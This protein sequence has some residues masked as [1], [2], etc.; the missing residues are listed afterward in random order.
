LKSFFNQNILKCFKI[1]E[2]LLQEKLNDLKKVYVKNQKGLLY[3]DLKI[4][5]HYASKTILFNAFLIYFL[6]AI[7]FIFYKIKLLAD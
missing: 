4:K 1:D 5:Q 7:I 2:Q 3:I 6:L